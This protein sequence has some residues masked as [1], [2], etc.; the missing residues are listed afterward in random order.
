MYFAVGIIT[1]LSLI[2][3]LYAVFKNKKIVGIL[4][5][6]IT[7]VFPIVLKAFCL[8]KYSMVY[9]D[10]DWKFLLQTAF[11][12]GLIEP[13]FLL[14]LFLIII[15]FTSKSLFSMFKEISKNKSNY[16]RRIDDAIRHNFN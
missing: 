4:Q 8:L 14:I 1:G 7:I 6:V 10:T 12:D 15:I 11:I 13:W 2:S 9:G 3:G 16:D 5:M